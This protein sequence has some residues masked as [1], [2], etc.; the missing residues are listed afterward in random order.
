[1]F[2]G[3]MPSAAFDG[4]NLFNEDGVIGEGDNYATRWII[5]NL[6]SGHHATPSFV[7][8]KGKGMPCVYFYAQ[9]IKPGKYV[10]WFLRDF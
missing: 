10:N 1:M 6:D 5:S 8:V 2:F 4:L 7:E 9:N 3:R